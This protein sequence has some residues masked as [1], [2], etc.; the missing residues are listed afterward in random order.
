MGVISLNSLNKLKKEV[1]K[2]LPKIKIQNR[3]LNM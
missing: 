3:I 1:E 2:R